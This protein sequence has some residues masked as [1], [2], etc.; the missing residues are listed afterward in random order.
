MDNFKKFL[1]EW[2][3]QFTVTPEGFILHGGQLADERTITDAVPWEALHILAASAAFS[4]GTTRF[5][6]R[7]QSLRRLLTF[8]CSLGLPESCIV[9]EG[10]DVL[11]KDGGKTL[12][13]R[14][15]ANSAWEMETILAAAMAA[16]KPVAIAHPGQ[17][18]SHVLRIMD[19][20]G[21]HNP[22][23]PGRDANPDEL[24]RRLAKISRERPRD[25][26]RFEWN[27]RDAEIRIPGDV[28]LAAAVAGAAASIARSDVTIREVLWEPG[29][30]GFFRCAPSNAR[31]HRMDPETGI[32][33]RGGGGTGQRKQSGRDPDHTGPD[34]NH[35]F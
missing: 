20:L 13:E 6:N 9:S 31:N 8:L 29:R 26:S 1:G 5:V 16:G 24:A 12:P 17:I 23:V 35:A 4:P 15:R 30:K 10:E 22:D 2:G 25:E 18:A 21:A 33:L 19:A 34:A 14:V 32:L 3:A 28:T 7:N 27:C 11:I